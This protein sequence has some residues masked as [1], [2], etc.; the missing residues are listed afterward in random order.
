MTSYSINRLS[1][2][3]ILWRTTL[4]S[5]ALLASA[6]VQHSLA[7]DAPVPLKSPAWSLPKQAAA[8]PDKVP[9]QRVTAPQGLFEAPDPFGTPV[10]SSQKSAVASIKVLPVAESEPARNPPVMLLKSPP[11][12]VAK[13]TSEGTVSALPRALKAPLPLPGGEPD[14][15]ANT[16]VKQSLYLP[17]AYDELSAN[18]VPFPNELPNSQ[19]FPEDSAPPRMSPPASSIFADETQKP[20]PAPG[21]IPDFPSQDLEIHQLEP[22]APEIPAFGSEPARIAPP[23]TLQQTT[24]RQAPPDFSLPQ[25]AFPSAEPQLIY[26][27]PVREP[28][29]LEP[30]SPAKGGVAKVLE[31]VH[32]VQP[33]ENYWTISRQHFGTAR[34]FAALAAYNQHRIPRPDRMK[35][36]MFVLVPEAEVLEQR[37]PKM[38][39]IIDMQPSPESLLKPGYFI[40]EGNQPMYR[41]GK[42]DTLTDIAEQHLGRTARWTQIVGMNRDA[43]KDG[44][45]LKIGMV[46]RLPRDASQV[47]LVP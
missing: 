4:Y 39:G 43:L 9:V 29:L 36:G 8:T 34:Y 15:S 41:I 19:P 32:E 20:I 5:T 23:G 14:S 24:N 46:L 18:P 28:A 17:V 22:T 16:P 6:L 42:G 31:E 45:T 35:P 12:S 30:T 13:E 10:N 21:T 7:Q 3:V 40:G 2:R 47:S 1:G 33:G 25:E 44:N 37:Y 27:P 38:A 26:D 11:I